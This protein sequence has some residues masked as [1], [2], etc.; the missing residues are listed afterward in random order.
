MAATGAGGAMAATHFEEG[1]VRVTAS[2]LITPAGSWPLLA[3]GGA[4]TVRIEPDVG[5]VQGVFILAL[6]AAA[7]GIKRLLGG[8]PWALA[9]LGLAAAIAA[10]GFVA[11]RRRRPMIGLIIEHD[12][13]AVEAWRSPDEAAVLRLAAAI[14]RARPLSVRTGHA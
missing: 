6:I 13:A 12:G 9:F 2:T 11:A 1:A 14:E 8:G 5:V 10:A 7:I 4:R 3:I